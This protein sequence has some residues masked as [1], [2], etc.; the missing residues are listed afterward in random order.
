MRRQWAR[1]AGWL[2]VLSISSVYVHS[3][4]Q[5]APVSPASQAASP[6][7]ALVDKYCVSCHNQRLRTAGL[8]L[9]AMNVA[10]VTGSPDV[11]EK[12][13][14]KL[15]GGMMPPPGGPRPDRQAADA[16]AS[17]LETALDTAAAA[18]PD[19]GRPDSFRRL[20]RTEYQNAIRDLLQ[21]DVDVASLVPP[22]DSSL[23]FDNVS[24]A[25]LS[26]TLLERYLSAAKVISRLA[27]GATI[28]SPLAETIFL[29]DDLTQ[30]DH[31][32]E[33]P[34]GTRGGTVVRRTFPVDGDYSI[35]VRLG[36]D[37]N[38]YIAGLD[39]SHQIEF[40]LDGERVGLFTLTP[41]GARG[42]NS[43]RPTNEED[44]ADA[45]LQVRIPVKAGPR[46]I[47]VTFVKKSSALIE[48][49][50]QPWLRR[51]AADY[52][53]QRTQPVVYSL[54]LAG[55]YAT[56]GLGDTPSR[57][58]I[59]TCRPARPADEPGCAKTILSALAR[60][61]Y[62][63][64]VTEQDVKVLLGFYEEGRPHGGFEVGVE[65]ALRALLV[66]PQFLFRIEYDPENVG[67]NT[68]YR[69]SDVELAS[70]LSFF[71]W[72]SIPDDELLNAAIRGDL[73]KPPLLEL[74]V[75]R[76]LGDPRSDALV[77]NF[78]GQW[79]YLRNLAQITPDPRLFPDFDDLLR[80]A[81]RRETELFF[82]SVLRENRSVVDLLTADYTF[83]NE[84]LARHYGIP[85][86]YGSQFRRIT[87]TDE[88]RRGLLG[89]GSILTA[90]AYATRTSPVLRGK[91]I[92]ENILGSPPPPPP[93]NV[94]PLPPK[95]E[96][97]ASEVLT[98]RE[99]MAQ[100][101][102]SPACSRC[103]SMI[104]P[105]GFALEYFDAVGKWRGLDEAFKPIDGSGALPDGS[106]FDDVIGL[107]KALLNPPDRFV[108]TVTEKLLTYA[109][110]RGVAFSDMPA[111]RQIVHGAAAEDYK[112]SSL[113][114]RIVQSTPFQMRRS[115][116]S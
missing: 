85:N 93:P 100:H 104:D 32:E 17:Y 4:G 12:V 69:L 90:T 52:D 36:R 7:R 50:R 49:T 40:T 72:S 58:R 99:R 60:H 65:T 59:F 13:V 56:T 28:R 76:M 11:W 37:R 98:M 95:D 84:R 92:L 66:S 42:V 67:P 44:Q 79:L 82:A 88:N 22:D 109:L 31:F 115:S 8:A 25:G 74:Q 101:R 19:P 63:R 111:V 70:R 73:K 26:P 77:D 114:L 20:N 64:A 45:Q 81:F 94:P 96:S 30:D 80:Q 39:A 55:P 103:H 61:A 34:F 62:R 6:H 48:T 86:V 105:A 102:A 1:A 107:R 15:R 35:A 51:H 113:I 97:G 54:S 57:R 43:N 112:L 14:R 41:D 23:G 10:D 87:L 3:S 110:G 91:W 21:L 27:I 47:G 29:P 24:V 116:Q 38:G 5:S 71:L 33:L 18:R 2:T 89:Q 78:A 83:V 46:D 68:A 106:R 75:R 108:T 53:D 9:D 16:F